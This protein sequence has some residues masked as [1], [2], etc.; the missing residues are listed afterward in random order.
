MGFDHFRLDKQV[1]LLHLWEKVWPNSDM[2]LF[3]SDKTKVTF[4]FAL[5]SRLGRQLGQV[6]TNFTPR[7]KSLS[8]QPHLFVNSIEFLIHLTGAVTNP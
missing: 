2:K 6:S 1:S 4:E 5:K 8:T 7:E 3:K